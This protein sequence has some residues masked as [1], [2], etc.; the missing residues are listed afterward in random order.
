MRHP[1][2]ILFLLLTLSSLSLQAWAGRVDTIMVHSASMHKDIP[3]VVILPAG[4]NEGKT[5]FPVL[6]LLHGYSGNYRDWITQAPVLAGAVDQYQTLIVCPDGGYGSWYLDS[7]MDSA[8]RYETFVATE[9]VTAIDARYRTLADR[10]HRAITG[11]SMGGHGAFY[12]ALRHPDEFGAVGSMSGGVDIR[13][14][15]NNWD[16][17]KRL[18]DLATHPDNWEK[19]TVINLA[20]SLKPGELKI[21]FECGTEDFFIKVN[22]ALHEKLLAMGIGHDYTERPGKH[23]WDYWRNAIG[24]QLLFFHRFFSGR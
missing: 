13:P 1:T 23:N 2:R 24:Y 5:A 14:F 10:A 21:A 9:L 18:G 4:Y 7:P 19:N 12:L 16:L 15:P 8:W 22:R 11:L 6:Y 20:D 17:K 3:C